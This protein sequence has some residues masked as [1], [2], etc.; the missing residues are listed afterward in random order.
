MK[1]RFL[2]LLIVMITIL[3]SFN[4]SVAASEANNVSFSYNKSSNI[5][6]ITGKC[7]DLEM[8]PYVVSIVSDGTRLEDLSDTNLPTALKMSH[9][10]KNGSV[11]LIMPLGEDF[12]SGTYNVYFSSSFF[13]AN[14]YF[15]YTKKSEIE[16]KLPLVN[17]AQS[18]ASLKNNVL[19]TYKKE[20]GVDNAIYSDAGGADI[21]SSYLYSVKP[22]GGY[23]D[24]EIFGTYMDQANAWVLIKNENNIYDVLKKYSNAIDMEYNSEFMQYPENVKTKMVELIKNADYSLKSFDKLIKELRVL[25][26][27]KTSSSWSILMKNIL[28]LNDEGVQYVEN[29]ALFK[30]ENTNYYKLTDKNSVY[31]KM[32]D[33]LSS[34]NTFSQ[35]KNAFELSVANAYK[36]QNE[37]KNTFPNANNNK[38]GSPGSIG[39]YSGEAVTTPTQ[40]EINNFTD[41]ANHWANDAVKRLVTKGVISGFPDG[42][43]R[44][45]QAVTRAEFIKLLT[46]AFNITVTSDVKFSDVSENDWY[47]PYIKNGYAAGIIK[48]DDLGRF[49]PNSPITREDACVMLYRYAR[50]NSDLDMIEFAFN[51]KD[52]ISEYAK[53]SVLFLYNEKVIN[54]VT[55]KTFVPKAMTTRAQAATLIS[56]MIDYI[57]AH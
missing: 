20:L 33:M 47:A 26:F 36:E 6:T 32:F 17:G 11:N 10:Q 57:L 25:A 4:V 16:D 46:L 41:M 18:A 15:V 23:K 14:D 39:S 24:A 42:S 44:P 50:I 29:I 40:S 30:P 56:R 2:S 8:T 5:L 35:A 27:V 51:D 54:G 1:K 9:T 13:S 38:P 19:N 12:E 22:E 45:E 55:P 49:L 28:G 21:I 7:S 31:I 34:V 3:S 43:F 48:G 37:D 52:D 53:D